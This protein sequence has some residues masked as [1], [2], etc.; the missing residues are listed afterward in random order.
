MAFIVCALTACSP[1]SP[2]LLTGSTMGTTYSIKISDAIE[3]TEVL[4]NQI[5]ALLLRI[6]NLMSTYISDSEL[7]KFNQSE[8]DIPFSLSTENVEVF[9]MAEKIHEQSKGQF[10]VTIGPLVNLWG[11]GPKKTEMLV[12]G[13]EEIETAKNSV[14]MQYLQISSD[15]VSKTKAVYVDLSAIAKGYGV[16]MIAELLNRKG[17]ENYLVEIG[18]ELR[19]KGVND[20]GRYWRIAIEKPDVMQ[21]IPYKSLE[22]KNLG[23]ATS[24]DYRNYFEVDGS[25]YSHTI[26][27][28]S[29]RPITHNVASVTVIDPSTAM[30]DGYA[31]AINV[32]GVDA[33]MKMSEELNLAVLMIIK[34]ENGF[35]ERYSSQYKVLINSE[36]D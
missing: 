9:A 1:Q 8:M 24:G 22:L 5:D 23:M 16:D 31:T 30:A 36:R 10:D 27:P 21:R 17:I 13:N 26:S 20:Q 2:T 29:G 28:I 15:R 25:R 3:D 18:G 32:M 33:G 6:N 12:P 35:E 34:T 11:F 19:A 14:G 4:Q 7:S